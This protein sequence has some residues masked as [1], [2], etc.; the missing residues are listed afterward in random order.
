VPVAKRMASANEVFPAP[1]L[2]I[3]AT[4][5]MIY[6][7]RGD[8]KKALEVLQKALKIAIDKGYRINEG[9]LT[10]L[11]GQ[12]LLNSGNYEQAQGYLEKALKVDR[13]YYHLYPR[14]YI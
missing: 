6:S 11:I 14:W 5:A 12:A 7:Y 2:E 4:F 9:Q 10:A 3:N 1:A 8:Y 13:L